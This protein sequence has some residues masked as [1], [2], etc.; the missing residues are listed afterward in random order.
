MLP[1]TTSLRVQVNIWPLST[2]FQPLCSPFG[3]VGVRPTGTVSVTVT[4]EPFVGPGPELVAVI[5][6]V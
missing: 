2:Q 6:Y 3:A 1:A 4:V 5:V